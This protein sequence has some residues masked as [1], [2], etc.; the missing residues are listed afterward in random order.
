[1]KR[2]LLF[3]MVITLFFSF[4]SKLFSQKVEKGERQIT[5]ELLKEYIDFLASDS[6]LGRRAPGKD[7]DL[8]ADYIVAQLEKFKLGKINGS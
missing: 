2:S 5:N 7:L 4:P 8:A 6:L 3:V 1:M